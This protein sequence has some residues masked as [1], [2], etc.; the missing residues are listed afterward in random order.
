VEADGC[1]QEL[2]LPGARA[3]CSRLVLGESDAKHAARSVS[4]RNRCVDIASKSRSGPGTKVDI[5]TAEVHG[6]SAAMNKYVIMGALGG[7]KSTQAALLARGFDLVH[8]NVGEIFRW[9]I[10]HHTKMGARVRRVVA[11]GQLVSDELVD[12][13]VRT[14]LDRHD[15][16]YGFVL[17]GFPRSRAQAEFLL[18]SY[19]IDRVVHVDI[20]DAVVLMRIMSRRFCS[21]CGLDYNLILHRPSIPNLC[22][23]CGDR[24]VTRPE[25]SAAALKRR[26]ND[27]H[28]MTTPILDVFRTR[29]LLIDVDGVQPPA[30]VQHEI[31]AQ[32]MLPN[33]PRIL[34]ETAAS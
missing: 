27:S 13:V 30:D 21:G 5:S 7:G 6:R 10:Q 11:A 1:A 16:N 33:P 29:A 31:R 9:N 4:P 19:D 15:W 14:R 20:P 2:R 24:L 25:D 8:I 17:D 28:A 12:D 3:Q 26:M 34:S 22:D 32:L 18:E 23:I